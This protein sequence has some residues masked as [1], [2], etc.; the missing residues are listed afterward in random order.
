MDILDLIRLLLPSLVVGV[1]M[2]YYNR[3]Q[4]KKDKERDKIE[5]ARREESLLQLEL[6]MATAKLSSVRIRRET[7]P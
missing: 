4:T 2:A 6:E 1:I 7:G 3:K 5:D